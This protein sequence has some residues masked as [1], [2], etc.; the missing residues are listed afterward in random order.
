[1]G[2]QIVGDDDL[3]SPTLPR[4]MFPSESLPQLVPG[5]TQ[6]NDRPLQHYL[7]GRAGLRPLGDPGKGVVSMATVPP[8]LWTSVAGAAATSYRSAPHHPVTVR[9]LAQSV[10][11]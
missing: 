8:T 6:Q 10:W 3:A 1:M 4:A 2:D 5:M 7:Y 9:K 11:R